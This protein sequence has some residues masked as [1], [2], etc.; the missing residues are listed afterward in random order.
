MGRPSALWPVGTLIAG[1]P[2]MLNGAVNGPYSKI[3]SIQ[4]PMERPGRSYSSRPCSHGGWARV[5]V[6][7]RSWSSKNSAA[8]RATAWNARKPRP[9]STAVSV[10]ARSKAASVVPSAVSGP[11]VTGAI[12]GTPASATSVIES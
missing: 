6:T 11:G 10:C 4:L 5:G 2:P 1:C 12:S 7:S 8:D 3:A 9:I